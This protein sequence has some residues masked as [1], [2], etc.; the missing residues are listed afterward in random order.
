METGFVKQRMNEIGAIGRNEVRIIAVRPTKSEK[1]QVVFLQNIER[2]GR[3]NL[4]AQANKGDERFSDSGARPFWISF[5]IEGLKEMLPEIVE[6]AQKAKESGEYVALNVINP[7][8]AQT[9][10]LLGIQLT[11]THNATKR[12]IENLEQSAKQDGN[13]HYLSKNG[14]M[15]FERVILTYKDVAQHQ[16]IEHDRAALTKDLA[17]LEVQ[18]SDYPQP[19]DQKAEEAQ[20]Q[21]K[22]I[23]DEEPVP[24]ESEE[25]PA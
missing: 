4:M 21:Q 24:E 1:V 7:K 14:L 16:F 23:V 22:E 13:G 10:D 18:T 8:N 9:G 20:T 15:I 6:P 12:D 11:E 19:T 25:I 17:D 2:A 3:V 5:T